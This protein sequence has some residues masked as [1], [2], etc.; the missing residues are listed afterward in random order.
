MERSSC[1]STMMVIAALSDAKSLYLLS[2]IALAQAASQ[3]LLSE[4]R[5]S[6]KAF[7]SRLSRLLK[8][9]IICR[10]N[11]K[12]SLTSF[13][14]IVYQAQE[15]IPS[16]FNNYCRLS[17]LDSLCML[18]ALPT[19]E[20]NKISATI[21]GDHLIKKVLAWHLGQITNNESPSC[22]DAIPIGTQ[23]SRISAG[24]L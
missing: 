24:G 6:A 18:D 8:V 5:L 22:L 16:A 13:G 1:I 3:F 9:G 23:R 7:Y 20:Y 21:L 4:T 2:K 11:G 14:K 19:T 17:A 15:L 12:Y 10:K